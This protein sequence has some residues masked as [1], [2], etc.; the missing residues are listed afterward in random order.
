MAHDEAKLQCHAP[1]ADGLDEPTT[2][3]GNATPH[4]RI[5]RGI[6]T[7]SF[8]TDFQGLALAHAP[9]SRLAVPGRGGPARP[10]ALFP[11]GSPRGAHFGQTAS[12]AP[13]SCEH[14]PRLPAPFRGDDGPTSDGAGRL[15]PSRPWPTV[16]GPRPGRPRRFEGF[17]SF[18][19]TNAGIFVVGMPRKD[20]LSRARPDP[21]ANGYDLHQLGQR[22]LNREPPC[23]DDRVHDVANPCQHN[24]LNRTTAVAR[25]PRSP[26]RPIGSP[27]TRPSTKPRR[28]SQTPR[29]EGRGAPVGPR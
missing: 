13:A 6:P 1:L 10:F 14:H 18:L 4:R 17:L 20:G 7:L 29:E 11:Q 16:Q 22:P 2:R 24:A 28:R 25:H 26:R 9:P 3:P 8:S 23:P 19:G 21:T 5:A 27:M 12:L 15:S